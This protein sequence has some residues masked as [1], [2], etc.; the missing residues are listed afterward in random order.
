MKSVSQRDSKQVKF[1]LYLHAM[2]AAD[3]DSIPG[4]TFPR[5]LPRVVLEH[6]AISKPLGLPVMAQRSKQTKM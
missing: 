3:A 1:S 4:T 2:H 6:R 5:A